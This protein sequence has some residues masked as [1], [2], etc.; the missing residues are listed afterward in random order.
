MN[1]LTLLI[2]AKQ[3]G[4][5]LPI[6]L[7]EIKN[8]DLN[9]LVV[10]DKNDEKTFMATKNY[11]CEVLFQNKLGYGSALIEGIDRINTKY[12]CIFNA[13]GSFQPKELIEM[14]AKIKNFDFV[15]GTRYEKNCGSDDD[16]FLT[17]IGNFFFT[18]IGNIFFNL[19]ITDILY[20]FVMG[21]TK[22]FKALRLKQT[23]FSTCPEIPINVQKLNF[24]YI[25]NRCY[26]RSRLKGKKKVNEFRDG[27]KIL[28]YMLKKFFS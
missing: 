18:K 19:S 14:Y 9:I 22:K 23:D 4:E 26:E 17:K 10:M 7:E 15:F 27:L 1:D 2:P 16:S 11:K 20:T 25:N 6:V 3:E 5:S 8:Y 28:F 12:L 13:D 21:D 24:T